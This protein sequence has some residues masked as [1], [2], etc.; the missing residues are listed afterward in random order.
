VAIGFDPGITTPGITLVERRGRGFR[1]VFHKVLRSDA[2]DSDTD[3]YNAITD[4]LSWAIREF[5]PAIFV[6]EEQ[7]NTQSAKQ[8]DGEKR[9]N[10]NNSK[11]IITVGLGCAVARLHRVP[12]LEVRTQTARAALIGKMGGSKAEKKKRVKAFVDALLGTDLPMD[13]AEAGLNAI[14]GLSVNV[15]EISSSAPARRPG[16][17]RRT[18]R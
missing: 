4:L 1:P 6:S 2:A 11:T 12:W 7:R 8:M 17:A 5:H 18:H 13:A 9:F 10:A 15:K 14:Y 16:A 3:R